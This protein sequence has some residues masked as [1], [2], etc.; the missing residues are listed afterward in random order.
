MNMHMLKRRSRTARFAKSVVAGLGSL[1]TISAPQASHL[2]PRPSVT[3]A[4]K[5][6][7]ARIGGDMKNAVEKERQ[8]E[9]AAR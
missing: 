3:G 5:A 8:S 6:D 9:K 4:L 7:F 2:P 1:L